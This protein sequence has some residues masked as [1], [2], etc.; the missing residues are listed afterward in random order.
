MGRNTLGIYVHIPFCESRCPYCGFLSNA[1]FT[2][3]D[4]EDYID[5]LSAECSL[6]ASE[7]EYR[8][9]LVDSIFIGGGTPSVLSYKS[10]EKLLSALHKSFDITDDAEISMEANPS[11]ISQ[12]KVKAFKSLM[13]NR[14]SLGAQ[15]FSRETL[16]L[17]GRIHG[18][19]DIEKAVAMVRGQGIDN[20]NLDLMLAIPGQPLD[21]FSYS[22]DRARQLQ[23]DHL[24]FY[25]LQLEEGT[26][27]YNDY[28]KEKMDLIDEDLAHDMYYMAL[29]RL[30][31]W[32]FHHYEVSNASAYGK[33]SRHNIKYWKYKDFLGLGLGAA[34]FLRPLRGNNRSDMEIWSES[35]KKSR[36]LLERA[37]MIEEPLQDQKKIFIMTGLRMRDGLDLEEFERT[38]PGSSFKDEFLSRRQVR[39]GLEMGQLELKDGKLRISRDMILHSNSITGYFL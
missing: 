24:S 27:F 3:G 23:P 39:A 26:K 4:K 20:L 30:E 21:D 6:A 19:A 17:L 5:L 36:P 22:L 11:S 18:P 15:S 25:S 28:R 38:F 33:E 31:S 14:I 1:Q 37:T 12:D 13:G 10:I 9:Y 34:S 8:D 32:G 16:G 29:D 7:L 35:I 2:E